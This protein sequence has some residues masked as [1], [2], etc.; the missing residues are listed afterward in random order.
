MVQRMIAAGLPV[1]LLFTGSAPSSQEDRRQ[2]VTLWEEAVKAKG[3]RE[4]LI[5]VRS[6]AIQEKT[7]FRRPTLPAWDGFGSDQRRRTGS[8]RRWTASW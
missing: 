5:A 2:A 1:L 6:F 3:G 4:A 8:K 7:V